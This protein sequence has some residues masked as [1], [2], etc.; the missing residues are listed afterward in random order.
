M[1]IDKLGCTDV[2]TYFL[3][4]VLYEPV[5]ISTH[6]H[7]CLL[8]LEEALRLKNV[9]NNYLIKAVGSRIN[10]Y[11]LKPFGYNIVSTRTTIQH[12]T[13]IQYPV[14]IEKDFITLYE[15]CSPY[16]MT[17]IERMYSL[18]NAIEYI[19]MHNIS[20][21]MVECGVWKG[22]SSMLI[23]LTMLFLNDKKR[24]IYLYDTYA[25]MPAPTEKDVD[26]TG[27]KFFETWE[28]GLGNSENKWLAVNLEEVR[29]NLFSTGYPQEKLVFVKGKVEDTIPKVIPDSIALLRLDTDWYE[30]TY[31]ELLYLF[32]RLCTHGVLIID[33]YGHMQGAR[34]AVDKYLADNN[35]KIILQRIDYTGRI[36]VK[37]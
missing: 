9:A 24:N 34:K 30:S 18:Y 21:D 3:T 13:H 32:P 20:G 37:L 1:R 22:G 16:T 31:H 14:D 33:D 17:S 5:S 4:M 26:F 6:N 25:G 11:L 35:I 28:Q 2:D 29:S 10:R 19:E 23:A 15:Q 36:G 27:L 7:C 8:N 12:P